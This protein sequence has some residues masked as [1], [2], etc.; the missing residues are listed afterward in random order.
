MILGL[1]PEVLED[2]VGP[3]PLHMILQSVISFVLSLLSPR[4]LTQFSICPCL[5]G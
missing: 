5:I 4:E 2:R 1:Y 3:E